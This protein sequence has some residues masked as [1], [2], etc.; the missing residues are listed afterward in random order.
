MGLIILGF[1]MIY[2]SI[3]SLTYVYS[4]DSYRSYIK[5]N[6]ERL[7]ELTTEILSKRK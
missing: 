6:I 2:L 3:R 1:I 7:D 4:E 5:S